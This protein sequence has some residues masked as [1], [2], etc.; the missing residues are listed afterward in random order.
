MVHQDS[1]A[2]IP[3]KPKPP[4]DSE[5]TRCERDVLLGLE[6]AI[7]L[8][9]QPS[10]DEIAQLAGPTY[11]ASTVHKYLKQLERKGYVTMSPRRS[12]GVRLVL[13]APPI[14]RTKKKVVAE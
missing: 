10:L 5:L 7:K 2:V 8:H 3:P 1:V 13:A 14:R 12:R 11:W 6:R 9:G 4:N